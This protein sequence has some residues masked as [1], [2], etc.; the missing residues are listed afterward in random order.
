ML[1]NLLRRPRTSSGPVLPAAALWP[2]L[3]TALPA[4]AA[5]PS[6]VVEDLQRSVGGRLL[7]RELDRPGAAE[8]SDCFGFAGP[9]ESL[10][11]DAWSPEL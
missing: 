5:T 4:I 10:S 8:T 2:G 9:P 6:V 7:R 3:R 11:T 1:L